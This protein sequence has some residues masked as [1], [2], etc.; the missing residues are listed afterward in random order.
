LGLSI[1][2]IFREAVKTVPY[3]DIFEDAEW[4]GYTSAIEPFTHQWQLHISHCFNFKS[5]L[6]AI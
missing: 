6:L 5:Q 3:K 1:H 4:G 2:R